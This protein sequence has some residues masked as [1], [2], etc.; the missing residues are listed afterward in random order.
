MLK[1]AVPY[2]VEKRVPYHGAAPV[3]DLV[4]SIIAD[5][6]PGSQRLMS[7][8]LM[9]KLLV[10]KGLPEAMANRLFSQVRQCAVTRQCALLGGHIFINVTSC[11][12]PPF[13]FLLI[14]SDL[15]TSL[16]RSAKVRRCTS[17]GRMPSR[18]SASCSG[19][20]APP[21]Q[22]GAAKRPEENEFFQRLPPAGPARP[23]AGSRSTTA[24]SHPCTDVW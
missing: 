6:P 3:M 16:I 4:R 12:Y 24:P 19:S 20:A 5:T 11:R 21:A 8:G 23:R 1:R 18:R 9:V 22:P 7:A 17:T 10:E 13:F 14:R 2:H 15:P